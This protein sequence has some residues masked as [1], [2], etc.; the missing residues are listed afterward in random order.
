MAAQSMGRWVQ[1]TVLGGYT[2]PSA[3]QHAPRSSYQA[4]TAQQLQRPRLASAP[5]GG[6]AAGGG[7][8]ATVLS[9]SSCGQRLAR[10]A[11]DSCLGLAAG[12]ATAWQPDT[13]HNPADLEVQHRV[14]KVIIVI[15]GC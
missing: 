9:P 14:E 12:A 11:S 5:R 3:A 10:K 7:A 13:Q 2:G 4:T 8:A 1:G 15:H 6:W